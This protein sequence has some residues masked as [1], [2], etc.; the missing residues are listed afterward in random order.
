MMGRRNGLDRYFTVGYSPP[1]AFAAAAAGVDDARGVGFLA[2][3]LPHCIL[4]E[5]AGTLSQDVLGGYG[6]PTGDMLV[7]WTRMSMANSLEVRSPLL[8]HELANLP[9][10]FHEWKIARTGQANSAGCGGRPAAV[11]TAQSAEV[12]F[13]GTAG[14]LVSRVAAPSFCG[15][16]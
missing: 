6:Q 4:P 7:R 11:G 12:G 9:L 2:R 5:E 15:T 10:R 8:D 3:M 14:G 1:H 16:T 13:R